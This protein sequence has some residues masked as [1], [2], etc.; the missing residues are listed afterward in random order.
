MQT[1]AAVTVMFESVTRGFDT[2]MSFFRSGGKLTEANID[3]GLRQVRQALLEADVNYDVVQSFTDKVKAA[4]IGQQLL[5]SV[6]PS[7]QFVHLLHQQLTELMGRSITRFPE[8]GGRDD[9]DD[10]GL[11]GS[12]KTTTCG[13]LVKLLQSEGVSP[14]LVAADLQR[15]AAIDQLKILGEQLGVP[16]HAEDPSVGASK[17]VKTACRS[18]GSRTTRW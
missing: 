9:P 5:Q 6:N 16:V 2:A 14:M 12:G 8:K 15:P 13:K 11:Q 4:A 7:Q 18:R 1:L 10:V 17:C 3:G